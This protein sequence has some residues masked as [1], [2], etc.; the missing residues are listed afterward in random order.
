MAT[1]IVPETG[2]LSQ[3]D[4]EFKSTL[5]AWEIHTHTHTRY[6]RDSDPDPKT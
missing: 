3:K 5:P 6:E 2:R 4:E 1:P